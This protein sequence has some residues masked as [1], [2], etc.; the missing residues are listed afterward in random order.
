MPEQHG[1][2]EE[3]RKDIKKITKEAVVSSYENTSIFDYSV[4]ILL[5]FINRTVYRHSMNSLNY[6]LPYI[7]Y[8]KV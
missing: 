5:E 1:I 6:R 3:H 4:L 2:N 8:A 7:R